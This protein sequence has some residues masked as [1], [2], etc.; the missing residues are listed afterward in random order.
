MPVGLKL[1]ITPL[2]ELFPEEEKSGL[3]EFGIR[4]QNLFNGINVG[5]AHVLIGVVF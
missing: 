2:E 5:L 4:A 1:K 3:V